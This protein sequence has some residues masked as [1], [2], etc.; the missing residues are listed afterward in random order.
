MPTGL[1]LGKCSARPNPRLRKEAAGAS[2]RCLSLDGYQGCLEPTA[3]AEDCPVSQPMGFDKGAEK[4]GERGF[5]SSCQ[6]PGSI[7]TP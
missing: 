1:P 4:L 6:H 7:P 3:E 2:G 5:S